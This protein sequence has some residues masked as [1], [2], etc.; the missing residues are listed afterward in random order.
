MYQFIIMLKRNVFFFIS[1]ISINVLFCQFSTTDV[2]IDDRLLRSDEKHEIANLQSN[3]QNFFINT[4]WNDN[5]D[6]LNIQLYLQLIFE[7]VTQKGNEKR[8]TNCNWLLEF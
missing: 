8:L 1:F 6:D 2:T 4:S 5:Y 3:I 7:G